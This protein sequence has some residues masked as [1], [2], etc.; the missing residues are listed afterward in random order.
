MGAVLEKQLG[1]HY[2]PVQR[3]TPDRAVLRSV[4]LR[5]KVPSHHLVVVVN[6]TGSMYEG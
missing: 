4:A 5:A 1:L 3:T 2:H 6:H